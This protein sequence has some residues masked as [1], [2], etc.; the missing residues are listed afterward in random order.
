[1]LDGGFAA[2]GWQLLSL[3]SDL[4][5]G[6]QKFTPFFHCC[7][8]SALFW[9]SC[10]VPSRPQRCSLPKECRTSPWAGDNLFHKVS[11]PIANLLDLLSTFAL[12][13]LLQAS[14]LIHWCNLVCQAEFTDHLK[15]LEDWE[16][17]CSDMVGVIGSIPRPMLRSHY[18]VWTSEECFGNRH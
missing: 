1:M 3:F 5:P 6:Q 2:Q 11:C 13:C 17:I 8:L 14:R 7:S 18:R 10:L 12:K 15:L 16:C 4:K 9:F